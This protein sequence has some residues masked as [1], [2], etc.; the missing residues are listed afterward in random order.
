MC[1][2]KTLEGFLPFEQ[3]SRSYSNQSPKQAKCG[4]D[5]CLCVILDLALRTQVS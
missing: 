1:N 4:R 3:V 5:Y 2:G